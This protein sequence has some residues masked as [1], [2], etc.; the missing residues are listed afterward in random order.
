MI[1]GKAVYLILIVVA[2]TALFLRIFSKEGSWVCVG[3]TW[4]KNGNTSALQ[5]AKLCPVT[6]I[7]DDQKFD[8]EGELPIDNPVFVET[9]TNTLDVALTTTTNAVIYEPQLQTFISSP[10]VVKG[11]ARGAW[12]FE[13]SFPVKLLD[14]QGNIIATSVA[15]PESDPLTDDFVPFTSSL[16]FVTTSTTGT[17][18]ISNDNPSGLPEYSESVSL[19][20]KFL[21][22]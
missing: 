14:D 19:P 5:P 18:I 17:L 10:L 8:L 22:K 4:Q 7:T 12:Y 9:A 21:N 6:E 15:S 13:A 2:L 20:V 11:Q 3:G 16:E 1:K